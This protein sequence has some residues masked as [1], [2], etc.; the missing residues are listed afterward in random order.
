[1]GY[2]LLK[3]YLKS[4]SQDLLNWQVF[5]WAATIVPIFSSKLVIIDWKFALENKLSR[6]FQ[7]L[8]HKTF[9]IK[10]FSTTNSETVMKTIMNNWNIQSTWLHLYP[11][12][13]S[14]RKVDTLIIYVGIFFNVTKIYVIYVNKHK[15]L[16][17]IFLFIIIKDKKVIVYGL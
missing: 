4:Y 17:K 15:V 2:V 10:T 1:M 13:L 11:W 14:I 16:C 12:I 3:S 6:S 5:L 9:N 7:I 8:S